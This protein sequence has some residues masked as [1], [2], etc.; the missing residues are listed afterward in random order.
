MS[1]KAVAAI[2][3]TNGTENADNSL[4]VL[5]ALQT[6]YMIPTVEQILNDDRP[7][8]DALKTTSVEICHLLYTNDLTVS[9]RNKLVL[10]CNAPNSFPASVINV[11]KLSQIMH[12][13]SQTR[14]YSRRNVQC[15]WE[16]SVHILKCME[17]YNALCH[18]VI[19]ASCNGS[20][21]PIVLWN[22]PYESTSKTSNDAIESFRE[23]AA[24]LL[25]R[26]VN[27]DIY[28]DNNT[29]LV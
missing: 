22:L 27:W 19:T 4:K 14:S 11:E 18:Y 12:D 8:P 23:A 17:K 13:I 1:R 29:K 26:L 9:Q 5:I 3:I 24:H 15:A 7:K 28:F 20:G 21:E 16:R 25:I 10:M 2:D 6:N